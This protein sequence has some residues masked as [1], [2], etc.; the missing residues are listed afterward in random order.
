MQYVTKGIKMYLI[1]YN[2][3][4]HPSNLYHCLSYAGLLGATVF[5]SLHWA[6]GLPWTGLYYIIIACYI[7]DN[8]H[9]YNIITMHIL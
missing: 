3:L 7:I 2:I 8:R 1:I 5:P 6:Q 4:Y 9:T